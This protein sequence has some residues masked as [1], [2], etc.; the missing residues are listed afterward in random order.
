MVLAFAAAFAVYR[1]NARRQ[2]EPK[3]TTYLKS[4][5][6]AFFGGLIGAKLPVIL[7][8]LQYGFDVRTLLTGRT[9][10]GGLVGGTLGVLL[11]KKKLGIQGRHGHALSPRRSPSE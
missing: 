4:S 5:L 2:G 10:A 7:M 8:N 3:L 11:V 9:V 6:A 1:Y